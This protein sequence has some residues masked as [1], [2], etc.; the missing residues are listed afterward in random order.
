M[1]IGNHMRKGI[2]NN[3]HT[4]FLCQSDNADGDPNFIDSSRGGATHVLSRVGALHSTI[5]S[6]FTNSSIRIS[7]SSHFV[8]APDHID[9]NLSNK[10]WCIDGWYL[11]GTTGAILSK[12]GSAGNRSWYLVYNSSARRFSFFLS[13]DGTAILWYHAPSI[14]P[15]GV[16]THYAVQYCNGVGSIYINGIFEISFVDVLFESNADFRI[17]RTVSGSSSIVGYQQ[18]CRIT[19]KTI[20]Y[21]VSGFALPNRLH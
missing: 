9:F 4:I 10:N 7:M 18:A 12:D 15:S 11:T 1:I 17:G 16:W 21:P 19:T 14:I 3:S 2:G 20:P 8:S 5:Q 13:V 6:I